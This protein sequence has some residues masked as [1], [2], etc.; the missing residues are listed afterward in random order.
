MNTS[1]ALV[2][3]KFFSKGMHSNEV[4]GLY[5]DSKFPPYYKYVKRYYYAE[6]VIKSLSGKKEAERNK[7]RRIEN[8]A[9]SQIGVLGNARRNQ[10]RDRT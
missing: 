5:D 4:T 3:Q 7:K 6:E 8:I 1:L 10:V 9:V 2:K